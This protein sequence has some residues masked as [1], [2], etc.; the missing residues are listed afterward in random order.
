MRLAPS[1]RC[2][3]VES[4]RAASA[5]AS[6]SLSGRPI[7]A[8][9]Y[10]LK[11]WNQDHASSSS[12]VSKSKEL[13]E[14]RKQDRV[15]NTI[16]TA[17]RLGRHAES[18]DKRT[19]DQYSG[20][21]PTPGP[22]T[23]R[24]VG[25]P[26]LSP[27]ASK[28]MNRAIASENVE[29]LLGPYSADV[30]T[31]PLLG[32]KDDTDGF[33]GR[34]ELGT[35]QISSRDFIAPRR[36]L[37][38][39]D[40]VELRRRHV[41]VGIVLP[42]PDDV[43]RLQQQ[44]AAID[45]G[46]NK[47]AKTSN[48]DLY[49]LLA[50]G[51]IVLYKDT[52]VMFQIP[53]VIEPELTRAGAAAS[54]RY[55][56]SS[57]SLDA[58]VPSDA[59][60]RAYSSG[61]SD[62]TEAVQDSALQEEPVDEPRFQARA[63]VC[64]KLRILERLKEKELQRLLPSFQSLFLI[65]SASQQTQEVASLR[66]QRMD[67]R[68]GAITTF[69]AARLMHKLQVSW[70]AEKRGA[71]AGEPFTASTIYAAHVLLMSRP[72]HF[73]A[74]GL[75][76]R[77]SQLFTCR[78]DQERANL[79]LIAK[80][81][82][83]PAGSEAQRFI[84]SFCS[85]A[86][87]V[88]EWAELHPHDASGPPRIIDTPRDFV[89]VTWT[90]EDRAIIEFLQTSLGSRRELQDDMHGSIAMEIIKRAGGHFRLL[91]Y[92]NTHERLDIDKATE[93]LLVEEGRQVG[94]SMLATVGTD[95][96]GEKDLQHALVMRFLISI[97]ALPPWQNPI[98]LDTSLRSATLS[99]NAGEPEKEL[100]TAETG[101]TSEA[102]Q[103]LAR[104]FDMSL[105]QKVEAI[106]HEFGKDHSVYV[107]DDEGAFELDDGVSIEPVHGRDGEQAWIHVH[108][109]DPTAW[110]Q[111]D[112]PLGQRAERRFTT[113]YFPEARWAMLPDEFV[114]S[115][116]GLRPATST[117]EGPAS[118]EG[119]RVMT[120]SA[121]LDLSTGLVQ[122][123]R[124]R[125]A[126]IHNVH[127]ISYNRVNDI[128]SSPSQERQSTEL[129]LLLK[130]ATLLSQ[131]R[132]RSG[133]V[134]VQRPASVVSVSPLPL[135]GVPVSVSA[136]QRPY[137]FAGFPTIDVSSDLMEPARTE[138][139][140]ALSQFLVSELMVLAGRIAASY[141]DRHGLALPYRYQHRQ[142]SDR[143]T[144]QILAMRTNLPGDTAELVSP[145]PVTK[146]GSMGHGLVSYNEIIASGM[147]ISRGG[148]SSRPSEH[149]S[150][151][152]PD[153]TSPLTPAPRW[154]DAITFS[155]YTRA[156]SPLR[157]YP[158]MVTHWQIKHHLVKGKPRFRAS[159]I[160]RVLP[161]MEKREVTAKQLA[162]SAERFWLHA[163]LQRSLLDDN[164]ND[165]RLCGPFTAKVYLPEVRVNTANL[166]GRVRVDIAELV[167]PA[168]LEWGATEPPPS[169][170]AQFKVEPVSV[171]MAGTRASLLVRRV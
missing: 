133:A 61:S 57:S 11:S 36:N 156:T 145:S 77:T 48:K 135:P 124:V 2:A 155:G 83:A 66:K 92:P 86:A 74:D 51:R 149:F 58:P 5:R 38:P 107:I 111:P 100:L 30:L 102:T 90:A 26:K 67:L 143:E 120:F 87:K 41:A 168:D 65:D 98:R 158:D 150:L 62:K 46:E 148:Y 165:P 15:S 129:S 121:L 18:I 166:S 140:P 28:S 114:R 49:V 13:N 45:H 113:L 82:E 163:L 171:I 169:G 7:H 112:D 94:R 34:A 50:S 106:R 116:A 56:I 84:D 88:R 73:L 157:R 76:H 136:L 96:F 6:T 159:D 146:G 55:V 22:S 141:G 144:E 134:L 1:S 9:A 78:S 44:E 53:G 93:L 151:G 167:I 20:W 47:S 81:I 19:S 85:K 115:G 21:K 89:D 14:K 109:A 95:L 79:E 4:T 132:T 71:A 125:P 142:D 127:T 147:A 64:N 117:A 60:Q 10:V 91:P 162:R 12:S 43:R 3:F 70:D 104:K 153:A 154:R 39:G 119:Q 69:E 75:S 128:L 105:D 110:I 161:Q 27:S 40:F 160:A 137:F 17:S 29:T 130:A 139:T 123:T 103:S 99:E 138:K 63:S 72:S 59:S 32:P 131:N 25:R 80:W 101:V 16:L 42:A 152:I 33:T 97:G 118:S 126:I 35:S 108:V 52:D 31:R 170:T 24:N 164:F 37:M 122:D 23:R 8:S 68:T 54:E